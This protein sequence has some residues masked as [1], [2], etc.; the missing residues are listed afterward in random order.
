MSHVPATEALL[1]ALAAEKGHGTSV[2]TL[3]VKPTAD[4]SD[5]V[6][7]MKQELCTA[8]NIKCRL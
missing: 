1:T 2:V 8:A 3:Y 7:R 5:L 6:S 4:V